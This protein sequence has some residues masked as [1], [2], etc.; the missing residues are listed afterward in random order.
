MEN[1]KKIKSLG[2][3]FEINE[4]G[5]IIRNIKTKRIIK[6]TIDKDGYYQCYFSID[7]KII[8]RTTHKLVAECFLGDKPKGTSVDHIDRNKLN[9]HYSNLR[10]ATKS[11]Q[12][13]NRVLSD[14]II[15]QATQ[16]CYKWT[17]ENV[18]IKIKLVKDNDEKIFLSMIQAS[19]YL[20]NEYNM[21]VEQIRHFL[22]KRKC[23]LFDYKIVYER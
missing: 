6:Q 15:K 17:M 1:W 4:D 3:R 20:A 14:K 2:E 12:M 13:R 21:K 16:N 18:A 7:G 19:K 11:E 23:F 5:S 9:N 10:Y 8:H 22:K